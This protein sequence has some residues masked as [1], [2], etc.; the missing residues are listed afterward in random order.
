MPTI[1]SCNPR[2]NCG[3]GKE[4][5]KFDLTS[6]TLASPVT[7]QSSQIDHDTGAYNTSY[8]FNSNNVTGS[9]TSPSK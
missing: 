7:A 8:S 2:L 3:G 9:F 5:V 1:L 6:P 4:H